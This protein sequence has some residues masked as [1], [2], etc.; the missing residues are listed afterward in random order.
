M[1]VRTNEIK[2]RLND[3]ELSNLTNQVLESGLS[4][5]KF[6]RL[7]LSGNIIKEL[8]P[9]AYYDL[10]KEL[11]ANGNN[12]NQLTKLAYIQGIDGRRLNEVLSLHERIL[13]KLD[14]QIRGNN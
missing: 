13:S 3:D 14:K 6:L 11:N 12:L 10:I 7:V 9:I 5:E 4:R 2:V 8:P 1:A